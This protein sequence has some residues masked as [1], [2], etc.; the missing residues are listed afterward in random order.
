MR[1]PLCL[2]PLIELNG[3][4]LRRDPLFVTT[5]A[6]VLI[7]AEQQQ[8]LPGNA[9]AL[10]S[11]DFLNSVGLERLGICHDDQQEAQG[12]RDAQHD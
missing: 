6:S 7:D 4:D 5:L 1:V 8:L 2:R 12:L 9:T 3:D 11:R 10:V